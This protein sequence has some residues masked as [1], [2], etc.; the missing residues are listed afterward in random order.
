VADLQEPAE[1]YQVGFT[2]KQRAISNQQ[3]AMSYRLYDHME[4]IKTPLVVCEHVD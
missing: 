2:P 4:H 3:Y 1:M